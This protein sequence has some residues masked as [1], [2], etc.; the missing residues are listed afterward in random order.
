M[1]RPNVHLMDG[2]DSLTVNF[3]SQVF[4][5]EALGFRASLVS[6]PASQLLSK[7]HAAVSN[8][9]KLMTGRHVT[10]LFCVC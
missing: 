2:N 7:N 3:Q 1:T 8:L 6:S 4:L 5:A 10:T 9:V